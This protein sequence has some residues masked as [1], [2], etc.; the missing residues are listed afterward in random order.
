MTKKSAFNLIMLSLMD[1]ALFQLYVIVASLVLIV[2][3][4]VLQTAVAVLAPCAPL[5]LL[6]SGLLLPTPAKVSFLHDNS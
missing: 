3:T 2:R 4:I 5:A 6:D 1:S